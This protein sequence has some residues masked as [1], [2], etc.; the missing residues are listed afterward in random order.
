MKGLTMKQIF[1]SRERLWVSLFII[2]FAILLVTPQL[3]T[4]KVIL[5]SDSIFHYNRFYE[6]A[7]QLKNGNFSYFLSLYG[8]QQSGRIV[9]ALYGPFFA[10]LQGGL[11]LI[12]G[13][14]FRYQIVSRVL[15]HILAESSMYA[16][17]K[18]CKVKTSIALSLGLLYATTFSI[19]YW[20][21]RQGFSSWGAALLPYCFIPAIHYVFYQRVDQVRLAL[22]MALIFQIHVLSA[23]MLAM[24]YLPFYL[25]TFV[26]ATTSKKKE[27]ILKVL[28]AVILFLLLTVNVWGVL[29]YLR[30]ANHLLDPFINRE[31]GKN[32]IDGTARYWLYTPISLM[33][34]LILQFIYAIVNWKKLARWKRILHFI[35]FVFFFLSTGLFPWQYLVENGNTFAELIQFPFRFFVPAT[36]LLLA[37]TGLTVTRFV[38][39]RKSIAVLLFAFAGVGLIQNIMDTTDRVNSAAQDGELI[40]IVKHTYVEG[41]Y[42][43]ISLTMNDSDLSQFL[44]L[45]VKPTPDYVPIYGTIGKQNTY[46]LYYENIVTNQRTEKLIKDNYLV[47]T[48]QADEGE[49]LNLPIVVYKDSIL[50][51]NGKELDKD[52]YN[53]ST[54]GTP[55]V[56]S[57]EGKN[58]LEL[59]YHEPEW[60]FVAISA[61]LIVL[62]I[63][64]LQW[65]YIK[66]KTQR[67][68]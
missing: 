40:S 35:Y 37:I 60:L 61:P 17:L 30:G 33:V 54:I 50:T 25:Y 53:L 41:D 8:F 4:R 51:L 66:V 62:G 15:L 39:W 9:N 52:D 19:Q 22:S 31:I 48:W 57:Q 65:I 36:I 43:T 13:T 10:Y 26:K 45:V 23:L 56:S 64:G 44:N 7:M 46:D 2:S 14:W 29:L 47:L 21:M 67:V 16:L 55:T 32:G 12:S 63:I 38:N 42:Q 1:K 34:L 49:E 68:A 18:Q 58:K 20:T 59:R 6:A 3:F 27:T 24:M 28:I 5:G 11:I